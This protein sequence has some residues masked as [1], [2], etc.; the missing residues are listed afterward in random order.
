MQFV[1]YDFV[2]VQGK[3]EFKEWAASLEKRERAKLNEKL[4]KLAQHGDELYP[5][6]LAGTSVSGIQKLRSHGKVQ[7]RPL[8][9]KGPLINEKTGKIEDAYTLLMGAKEIGSK[10]NPPEAPEKANKKKKELIDSKGKMRCKH[11]RVS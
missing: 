3:N 1:L 6:M 2:N 4:D 9:C 11:E 8:L 5:E 10:W 7:L